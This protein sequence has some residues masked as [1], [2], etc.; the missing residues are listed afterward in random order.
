MKK[1]L[2]SSAVLLVIGI[3]GLFLTL[4]IGNLGTSLTN[5]GTGRGYD[6]RSEDRGHMSRGFLQRGTAT[7]FSFEEV[8]NLTNEYLER[9]NLS[10]LEIAEIM[11][12]SRNFYIEI[13]EPDT[14]ISA[15]ELLVDK[16]TGA[17][18]PEYGP[19]M[20][21]N[22]K[23]GMH[24]QVPLSQNDIDMDISED[25]AIQLA[26]RYLAKANIGE[27]V[28]DEIEKFYGYYTI[29]TLTEDGDI[30]GM[31]SVNGF[32]GEVWYHNWHGI[33]IDMEEYH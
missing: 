15:M 22:L 18:F 1:L 4:I 12:F 31:L 9:K 11:E 2:I 10:G 23:Y 29:H 20:M 8:E 6:F 14:G 24:P 32:T 19:N 13:F 7:S 17:I 33:F 5:F 16:N 27:F 30:A 26:E 28:G 21:W 3:L 25:R